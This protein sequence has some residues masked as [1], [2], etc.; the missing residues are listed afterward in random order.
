MGQMISRVSAA[1]LL[2]SAAIASAQHATVMGVIHD[3]VTGEELVG[4][5]VVVVGTSMGA[6]SDLDG[7]YTIRNAPTEP[8]D[9]RFSFV[10]YSPGLVTGI[11]VGPE[12]ALTLDVN[13]KPGE[14]EGEEVVVT[15]ERQ[16]STESSLLALRNKAA[17]IGDAVSAEQVKRSP[18]ATSADALRRVTGISVVDNKFVFVRGMTDRYNSTSLDGASVTSAE[19]GK[20]GFQFDLVPANLLDNSVVVKSSTPNLPGDF[21]GGLVQMH[22]IDFPDRRF[23]KLGLSSSY[24]SNTTSQ[25]MFRSQGGTKDW[26]GFDDGI[27]KYPGDRPQATM[28]GQ[29]L[30]NTWA[31]R[32]RR[33]P[34]NGSFSLAY[35]DWFG[36]GQDDRSNDQLGIVSALSYKNGYQKSNVVSDDF[37][38]GRYNVG[39]DNEYSVLWGGIVNATYR[40]S[41]LHKISAKNMYDHT[42]TDR[43]ALFD[44][45]DLNTTLENRYTVTSWTQRSIYTGQISGDHMFPSLGDLTLLWRFSLSSARR[46]DPDRKE[47]I[48][49]RC[50]RRQRIS[51]HGRI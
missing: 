18:D 29:E 7:R 27:R 3:A 5:N 23:I 26:A 15:A 34:Y 4:V 46:E 10:G 19:V 11:R 8:F 45:Q 6:T 32:S 13:L 24:N 38:V 40:I 22:T 44:S 43:V 16:L 48:P 12:E 30:A 1:I 17:T 37:E 31:P 51:A 35:G 9:L 14:I 42:A 50:T 41:G 36:L 47:S 25:E 2:A 33:A 21:T 20:K 49:P 39:T 28:L